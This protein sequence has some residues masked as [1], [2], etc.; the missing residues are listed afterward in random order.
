MQYI[1]DNGK[2]DKGVVSECNYEKTAHYIKDYL[3]MMNKMEK[4][5]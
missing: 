3:K 2:M 1:L 5:D 4:E